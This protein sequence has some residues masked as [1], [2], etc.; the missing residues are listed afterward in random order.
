MG[1]RRRQV[2][3]NDEDS[4]E[5]EEHA[6][7]QAEGNDVW[8]YG[9]V[10]KKSV[11][12]LCAELRRLAKTKKTRIVLHICSEGGDAYAGLAGLAGVDTCGGVVDVRMEGYVCSA[13]T[14]IAIGGHQRKVMEGCQVLV[15][16]VSGG[17]WGEYNKMREEMDNLGT[18]MAEMRRIYKVR[19]NIP[20]KEL[21]EMMKRDI[22]LDSRKAAEYLDFF[23]HT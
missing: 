13:A 20:E 16:Q 7:V 6:V 2:V 22:V 14:L 21:D 19:T 15:H 10:T 11:V 18:L 5:E 1:K 3:M 23:P 17:Q 12:K 9:P 8:F 4:L